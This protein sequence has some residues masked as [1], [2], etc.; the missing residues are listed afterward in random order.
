M[1]FNASNVP[2]TSP[3]SQKKFEFLGDGHTTEIE[4][5]LT[6]APLG[7]EFK[8]EKYPSAVYIQDKSGTVGVP[9]DADVTVDT[10]DGKLFVSFNLPIP[11]M[12][13]VGLTVSL[14]YE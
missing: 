9:K 4:I 14:W 6:Q 8:G 3:F 13:V 7:M 1:K 11:M 5:D 2:Q 12:E 10:Q